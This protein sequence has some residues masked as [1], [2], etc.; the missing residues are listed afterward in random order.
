MAGS[1]AVAGPVEHAITGLSHVT[2][3]MTDPGNAAHALLYLA[4]RPMFRA[5]GDHIATSSRPQHCYSARATCARPKARCT[6]R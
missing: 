5:T 2:S 3:A 6:T 1:G 4:D